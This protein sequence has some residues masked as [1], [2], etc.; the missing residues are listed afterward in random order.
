MYSVYELL[1]L[2]SF[3]NQHR[4]S[5][6]GNW[7]VVKSPS[8]VGLGQSN[9]GG[10]LGHAISQHMVSSNP[11]NGLHSALSNVFLDSG[12]VSLD[13]GPLVFLL[14]LGLSDGCDGVSTIC[15][16]LQCDEPLWDACHSTNSCLE[17]NS[18]INSVTEGD[19]LCF[20]GGNG[21]SLYLLAVPGQ[22]VGLASL[23]NGEAF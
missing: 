3:R 18:F 10:E 22:Q 7:S 9:L 4:T 5:V 1:I 13:Q 12:N 14:L 8:V 15:E 20:I 6:G 2:L 23:S 19:G 11:I 16:S 21:H 17:L